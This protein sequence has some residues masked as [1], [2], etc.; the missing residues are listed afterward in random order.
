MIPIYNTV[1]LETN[2]KITTVRTVLTAIKQRGVPEGFDREIN[3]SNYYG[4][5]LITLEKLEDTKG[6]NQNP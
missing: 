4:K 3:T 2:K 5:W 1:T 6:G